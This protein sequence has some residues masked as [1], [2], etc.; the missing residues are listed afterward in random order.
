MGFRDEPLEAGCEDIS[1]TIK[2]KI[3]IYIGQIREALDPAGS[4][5]LCMVTEISKVEVK[6]GKFTMDAK[7]IPLH[8]IEKGNM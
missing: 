4:N 1:I 8:L 5:V 2:S 7:M 6:R 3:D